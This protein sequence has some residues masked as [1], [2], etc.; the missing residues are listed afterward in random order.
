MEA[1]DVIEIQQLYARYGHVMDERDWEHLGELFTED[2]VFDATAL[3]VPLMEGLAAIADST[4]NSP[5]APLAHHVTNVYVASVHGEQARVQAK[6][7]GLYSKGRA[8]SGVYD[9]SLVRTAA[10][11]RIRRRV[12]RPAAA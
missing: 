9:D 11:W 1:A 2:C 5:A 10:G 7:I 8:F 4:E 6:A 3:G 12:N